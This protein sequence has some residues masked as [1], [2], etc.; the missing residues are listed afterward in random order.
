MNYIFLIIIL[1]STLIGCQSIPSPDVVSQAGQENTHDIKISLA[2]LYLIDDKQSTR[3]KA[4]TILLELVAKGNHKA[5]YLWA[6]N[7]F[8][9]SFGSVSDIEFVQYYNEIK[10]HDPQAIVS[11]IQEKH[12]W[13]TFLD[14]N[15]EAVA[16]A[17]KN[18]VGL[19]EQPVAEMASEFQLD[20]SYLVPKYLLRCLEMYS[21]NSPVT[22]RLESIAQLYALN[23]NKN[24]GKTCIAIGY[25]LLSRGELTGHE[26]NDELFASAIAL[27]TIFNQHFERLKGPKVSTSFFV[28]DETAEKVLKAENHFKKDDLLSA[29]ILLEEWLSEVPVESYDY[30]FVQRFIGNMKT[31]HA[32]TDEQIFIAIEHLKQASATNMLNREQFWTTRKLI[33]DLYFLVKD[34]KKYLVHVSKAIESTSNGK[35]L[36]P[37][38]TLSNIRLVYGKTNY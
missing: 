3:L 6:S 23:C 22:E 34:Y 28:T 32:K 26:T 2:S 15:F 18:G 1:I 38:Q 7:Q 27:R 11:F 20:Q 31:I 25:R 4:K 5:M 10:S 29:V 19:C 35:L 37:A 17:Y 36:V 8:T 33:G 16:L 9:G 30:A 14:Q 21:L 12:Q 24:N 13:Q